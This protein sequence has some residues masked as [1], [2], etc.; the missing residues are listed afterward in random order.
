MLEAQPM[1]K[2]TPTESAYPWQ[3]AYQA[4][5]LETDS[6]KLPGRLA[7]A[8]A[9]LQQRLQELESCSAPPQERRRLTDALLTL[10][11][12]RRIES[13]YPGWITQPS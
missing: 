9:L 5:V 3:P 8:N 2:S 7:A 1:Q 4:A 12:I 10:E 6:R 13:T 11:L